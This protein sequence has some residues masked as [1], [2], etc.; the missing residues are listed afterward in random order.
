[1]ISPKEGFLNIYCLVIVINNERG[2]CQ[3]HL[4]PINSTKLNS[5]SVGMGILAAL[6]TIRRTKVCREWGHLAQQVQRHHR[7]H[8]IR[9][10][11]LYDFLFALYIFH[12]CYTI[13]LI[14]LVTLFSIDSDLW[15]KWNNLKFKWWHRVGEAGSFYTHLSKLLFSTIEANRLNGRFTFPIY[16]RQKGRGRYINF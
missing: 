12:S 10:W 9:H 4:T 16:S 14:T 11:L 5:A 13:W 1:M 6:I 15:R 2:V 3:H 7:H 8:A